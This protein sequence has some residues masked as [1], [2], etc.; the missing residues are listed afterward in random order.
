MSDIL[1]CTIDTTSDP[2]S[3][4]RTTTTRWWQNTD[5]P[6]ADPW[7]DRPTPTRWRWNT[8]EPTA[9][10]WTDRPTPTRWRWNT[11][12]PRTA[13]PAETTPGWWNHHTTSSPN[14]PPVDVNVTLS[15]D[16]TRIISSPNY[17]SS[18]H[19]NARY[20]WYIRARPR[21]YDVVVKFLDFETE[22]NFDYLTIGTG[23]SPDS[24][25]NSSQIERLSGSSYYPSYNLP[26]IPGRTDLL[27]QDGGGILMNLLLILGRTDKLLQDGGG[28]LMNLLLTL[29]RTDQLRQDGGG[30][31]MNQERQNQQKRH[32]GGGIIIQLQVQTILQW[33]LPLIPG[34][35]DLLRQDGGGILMNLLLILGQTD[36]LR[37]DGGG[38][39][40]M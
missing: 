26:L 3:T 40:M 38:I 17:P 14:Y 36:Q 32:R 22:R 28:I 11:D 39:L 24:P 25:N 10:P 6:T 34:Q 9:D 33:N 21:G 16:D 2:W 37:Q 27:R 7:T 5:E 31:L 8:N 23:D 35:T 13:E 19:N 4:N 18:Y 20:T 30:I 1:S 12:E 29:G 15:I